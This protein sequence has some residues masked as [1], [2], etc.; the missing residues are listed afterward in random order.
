MW[1]CYGI[2]VSFTVGEEQ[3]QW[4]KLQL[5]QLLTSNRFKICRQLSA[6]VKRDCVRRL[7]LGTGLARKYQLY[8][9]TIYIMI[10]SWY[11]QA[12]ISWYFYIFWYFQY[13]QNI[14]LYYYYLLTFLIHA[15]LT[16]TAQVTKLLDGAKILPKILTLWV[17]RNNVRRQTQTDGWLMP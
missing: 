4:L 1:P 14:H 6:N 9:S 2:S 12:K 3:R 11:F 16:Q 15:Y 10:V 17:G 5:L 13:F 8:I 7:H